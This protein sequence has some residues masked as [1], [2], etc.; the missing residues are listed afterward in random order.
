MSKISWVIIAACLVIATSLF[1]RS[2][3]QSSTSTFSAT[4]FQHWHE[5]KASDKFRVSM[6]TL[7][8][9]ATEKQA[10]HLTGTSQEGQAG[11]V[12]RIYDMYVSEEANGTIFMIS[13]ITDAGNQKTKLDA[14]ILTHI[15]SEITAH[16]PSSKVNKMEMGKYKDFPAMDFSV[17][18]ADVNIDGK[19]FTDGNTLYVLTSVAKSQNYNPAEFDYFV[20]SFELL[21]P[22]GN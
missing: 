11:M 22:Q 8:Q 6:P 16:S 20:R 12:D 2:C 17:T 13:L 1:V 3:Q 7:P 4:D 15:M 10:A 21:T 19:A 18:N 9:H 14:S 5:F